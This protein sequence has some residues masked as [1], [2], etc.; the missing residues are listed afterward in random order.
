VSA[1]KAV[2]GARSR[3]INFGLRSQDSSRGQTNS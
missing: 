1:A 3:I 2:V